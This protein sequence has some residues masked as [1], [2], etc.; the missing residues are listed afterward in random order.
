MRK[1]FFLYF[2]A[3]LLL[4]ITLLVQNP[5][6]AEGQP[7]SGR[8][9]LRIAK[10]ADYFRIVFTADDATVQKAV[11]ALSKN[12]TVRVEFGRT[13][14]LML[15]RKDAD[16]NPIR[17]DP[18]AKKP[19]EYMKGV[20]VTAG[21]QSCSVTIESLTDTK[22]IKLTSPARL[23][24]DASFSKSGGAQKKETAPM[25]EETVMP[26]DALII[27]AGH[28]GEDKGIHNQLT[29]EKEIVL[30]IA[31]DIAAAVGKKNRTIT[32]TRKGDQSMPLDDRLKIARAQ[33]GAFYLSIHT[34]AGR[35]VVVYT[36]SK[37]IYTERSESLAQ[38]LAASLGKELHVPGRFDRLP[39]LYI[40][41]VPGPAVLIELPS[42]LLVSYDKKIRERVVKGILNGLSVLVKDDAGA[43]KPE[44]S[45]PQQPLKKKLVDEI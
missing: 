34:G 2:P 37:N 22:T 14:S 27:D 5:F 12:S 3:T 11:L 40:A 38:A 7:E 29:S 10:H 33:K 28:G 43:A 15:N 4:A 24:I 30:G 1:I 17:L 8:V 23:V 35:E 39:G 36:A 26:S 9:Q 19:V 44:R 25:V 41:A 6:A 31:R 16:G 32:L 21:P 42:P 45:S 20:L 13:V 18:A